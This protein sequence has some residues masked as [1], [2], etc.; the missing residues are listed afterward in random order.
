MNV[1]LTFGAPA[2]LWGLLALPL[3]VAAY[4]L[5]QRRRARYAV[6][7]TNLDLLAIVVPRTPAW[8]R[9]L[10]GAFYLLALGALLLGLARPQAMI[11]VPK[12][13]AT[14]VMVMD[15]SGSMAATDVQPSR[16]AAAKQAGNTFLDALPATFRVSVIGFASTINTMVGPT[17][18]RPVA[19]QA[20]N[21]LRADGGTAMGDAIQRAVQVAQATARVPGAPPIP[22]PGTAGSGQTGP[23]GPAGLPAAGIRAPATAATAT[24]PA[25]MP[26][27]AGQPAGAGEQVPAAI[28]LLSDGANTDGRVQPLDAA[29]AARQAGIPV[30]TIALG[31][32]DGVV[33]APAPQLGGRGATARRVSVPPD[34]ATLRQMAQITGGQFFTAPTAGDLRA[35][36]RDIGSRIGFEYERQEVTFVFAAAGALLFATGAALALARSYRFP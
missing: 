17:T 28:L 5:A 4:V 25:G 9:H 22:A 31:T 14:V 36:Y 11:P 18:D 29:R 35:V 8:Q 7:F 2:L 21:A 24:P 34:E 19:R 20:I 12:N 16:M 33:E 27:A 10:P 26:A 13:Q 15:T 3:A 6:R 30:Y 23:S 32:P 1:P